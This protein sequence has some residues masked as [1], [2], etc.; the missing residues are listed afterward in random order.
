[1]KKRWETVD[2][3][4]VEI[5]F[6]IEKDR[7]GYPKSRNWEQLLALPVVERDDYFKIESIPFYL[8]N[9]SRGDI[10]RA[11]TTENG[12]IQHG[13]IF[14]FEEIVDRGGHNTYRLLLKKKHPNDPEFTESELLRKGLAV[15]RERGDFFAIDVPSSLDQQIIDKYLIAEANSGRWEIQDG[16]LYSIRTIS[17]SESP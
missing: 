16:Y 11:K 1:M 12:E 4:S 7:D 2:D 17:D 14:A 6:P 5:W 9:V 3:Y 10:I 15:E 13:E 8:K